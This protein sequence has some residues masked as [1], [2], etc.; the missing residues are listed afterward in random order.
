MY[1][2]GIQLSLM[3]AVLPS[4]DLNHVCFITAG[5]LIGFFFIEKEVGEAVVVNAINSYY[6]LVNPPQIIRTESYGF[7]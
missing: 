4:H 5:L 1:I 2:V 6:D 7:I 3:K